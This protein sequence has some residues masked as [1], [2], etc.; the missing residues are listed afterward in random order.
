MKSPINKTDSNPWWEFYPPEQVGFCSGFSATFYPQAINQ[1]MQKAEEF[2]LKIYIIFIDYKTTFNSVE[3]KFVQ[4]SAK[5][6]RV[7]DKYIKK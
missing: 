6:Q 3:E 1:V 2:C 4:Q 7:Q 5:N